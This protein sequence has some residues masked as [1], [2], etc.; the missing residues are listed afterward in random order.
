MTRT[1][2]SWFPPPVLGQRITDALASRL[3]R[4]GGDGVFEIKEDR[5]RRQGLGLVDHLA[6]APRNCQN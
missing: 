4:H 3:L 1:T 6:A 5:V 2:F